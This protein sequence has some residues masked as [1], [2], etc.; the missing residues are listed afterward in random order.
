MEVYGMSECSGPATMSLS[1][2]LSARLRRLRDPGHRAELA[3]DG[4]VVIRGPHVFRATTT[5]PPRTRR[6]STEPAGCTRATWASSTRT[7]S[8]ASPT[9]RRS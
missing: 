9:A 4:E 6:R 5:T 7:A 1:R 8:C 3:E 2:A